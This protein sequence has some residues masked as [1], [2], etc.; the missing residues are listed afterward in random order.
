[1]PTYKMLAKVKMGGIRLLKKDKA[2]QGQVNVIF[3]IIDK[4]LDQSQ[5]CEVASCSTAT[6]PPS[7]RAEEH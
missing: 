2:C 4:R 3:G 7:P 6:A 1:M 5:G